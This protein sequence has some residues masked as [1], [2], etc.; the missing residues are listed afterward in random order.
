VQLIR[1]SL[2]LLSQVLLYGSSTGVSTTAGVLSLRNSQ[3][4]TALDSRTGMRNKYGSVM[5]T[6][7]R[8]IV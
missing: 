3:L 6:I 1:S 8:D 4:L 7:Y 2:G 5:F